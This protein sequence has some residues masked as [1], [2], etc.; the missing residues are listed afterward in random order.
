MPDVIIN[1]H[2][3]SFFYENI[4]KGNYITEKK[5]S[6][7]IIS[8]NKK[9]KFEELNN[10]IVL[11]ENADPGFDFLFSY[12]LKG[13][14]TKYGG[15]NSHMAIRCMEIDLPSITGVG[16]RTYNMLDKSKKIYIDCLNKKFEIIH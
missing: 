9:T 6:G 3:F 5:I 16:N 14:I 8:F 7:D 1:K 13:L 2:D 11:I 15:A 4:K 12:N 10:K